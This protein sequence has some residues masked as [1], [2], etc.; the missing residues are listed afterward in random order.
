MKKP[1]ANAAA[2]EARPD[3][4]GPRAAAAFGLLTRAEVRVMPATVDAERRTVEVVWS[5]GAIVR[6][7]D[8]WTGERYDEVL[9]LEA[10]HV[11]LGRLNAGAPLLDTHGFYE[12]ASVLGVVERAWIGDGASGPEGR[13]VVRFSDRETVEPVWRDVAGGIIRNISVGYAV[14]TYEIREED[15]KPPV[16]RA[17]DWE[18]LELSLVPIGADPGAGVRARPELPP[19]MLARTEANP[20]TDQ[21]VRMENED[22]VAESGTEDAGAQP[23]NQADA[24]AVRSEGR[25][26]Q[27]AETPTKRSPRREPSSTAQPG[28]ARAGAAEV[29]SDTRSEAAPLDDTAARAIADRAVAAER[30]RIAIIREAARKLGLDAAVADDLVA[31]GVAIGEARRLMIDATAER[32][33]PIRVQTGGGRL[34]ERETRRRGIE[35]ALL[36]RFDPTRYRLEEA[37]RDW[38]GLSLAELAREVLHAEGVKV[39]GLS[40]DEVASRAMQTTS[41]FPAILANVTGK[42]L[43]DAYEAAPKT[44][45]LIAR[46][47][48][49]SDFKPVSR[50]QLGEAPQ[51]EKVRESGEFKRGAIGEA[52]ESYRVETFGKVVAI[53]RQTIVNDDLDAFTRI[54]ALF[55]TAA[56]TLESD[57]VWGIIKDNPAMGDGVALFHATHK[58]LAGTG[59]ALDVVSLG[60]ARTAM[61]KQTGVDAKTIL[62][63]RPAFLVL[64]SAL[65][66]AGEQIVAQVLVPAKT[67]DVV[68]ASIRSISVIAEPRLDPASGAVPWYLAASPAAIDTIEYAYLDGQDGVVVETRIGFDVDGIEVRARL[69]FGAKAIDWRG[70]Y[71]NPGVVPS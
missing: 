13:A 39:R 63:V 55:G 16:W 24:D 38:R 67:S 49:V 41:D 45:Q 18:P 25:E 65:E 23:G 61:A 20:S 37:A 56:A 26:E 62:N 7:R 2:M 17:I 47:V 1:K 58:N 51:L 35:G 30:E 8:P 54:P 19:A 6:R 40:R 32:A 50:V 36:H 71:K 33:A 27:P 5:T 14:R 42:T 64:P 48:V 52:R 66:L 68:P 70:F 43:R 60:K 22:Q 12:V 4:G 3:P 29:R 28:A 21:E 69:D 9:S 57:V 44:Y 15:G 11:D 31:R 46:R 59:T 10:G 53:T 34:D